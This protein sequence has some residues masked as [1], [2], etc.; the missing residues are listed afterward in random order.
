MAVRK[1]VTYRRGTVRRLRRLRAVVRRGRHPDHRR[2]G[3]PAGRQPLR[4]AGRLPGRMPAGRHHDRGARRRRRSTRKPSTTT[5]RT[6]PTCARSIS[7]R[8]AGRLT[9]RRCPAP[10]TA[11]A[12]PRRLSRFA[13]DALP[14][15]AGRA[16]P[17]APAAAAD[18]DGRSRTRRLRTAPVAHPVAPGP[19]P[20]LRTSRAPT[21]C[22]PPTAARS[23]PPSSTSASCAARRWR[24][25]APSWTR[26]ATSTARS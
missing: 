11:T 9:R 21:C 7:A 8:D 6:C 3:R 25:P 4:R 16:V 14:G 1:I 23:P 2:Q 17:A 10:V 13:H 26:A 19:R 12:R 18:P 5:S 20:R 22:W 24:W 15:R